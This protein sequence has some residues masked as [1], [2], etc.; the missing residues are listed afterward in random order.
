MWKLLDLEKL[1]CLVREFVNGDSLQEYKRIQ[2]NFKCG[3]GGGG[4]RK[5]K[6]KLT[7][8]S[9]KIGESQLYQKRVIQKGGLVLLTE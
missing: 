7:K 5:W 8:V 9:H 2:R 1:Y 4:G 6:V 3:K